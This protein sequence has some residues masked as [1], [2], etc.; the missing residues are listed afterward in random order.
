MNAYALLMGS[1]LFY[2]AQKNSDFYPIRYVIGRF[3]MIF[4][5]SHRGCTNI[6][7]MVDKATMTLQNHC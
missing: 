4:F 7:N 3:H 5:C 6:T 2:E 1:I